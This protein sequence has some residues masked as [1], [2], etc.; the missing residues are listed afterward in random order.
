MNEDGL[1]MK[2]ETRNTTYF[3]FAWLLC[4]CCVLFLFGFTLQDDP[5]WAS[6]LDAIDA[7][8]D[9]IEKVERILDIAYYALDYHPDSTLKYADLAYETSRKAGHLK[10]MISV[11]VLKGI[12]ARS[13]KQFDQAIKHY[14][15]AISLNEPLENELR[16]AQIKDNLAN[17]FVMQGK[18]EKAINLKEEALNVFEEEQDTT[19]I[20][21]GLLGIGALLNDKGDYQNASKYF[22][23]SLIFAKTNRDKAYSYG[24]IGISHRH[25]NQPDSA[26][27]YYR[28]GIDIYPDEPIHL[29]RAYNNIAILQ[30]SENQFAEALASFE[31]AETAAKPLGN[32]SFIASIQ[33]NRAFLFTQMGEH[34]KAAELIKASG[35]VIDS[36]GSLKEKTDLMKV[37][38]QV[39]KSQGNDE[40]ALAHYQSFIYLRDSIDN[41]DLNTRIAD[42]EAK[43]ETAEKE[44]Q[45]AEQEAEIQ[46]RINQRNL[47]LGGLAGVIWFAT[48]AILFF[49]NRNR[50]NKVI[51]HQELEL[52]DQKI[53]QLEQEKRFL[54]I[55]SMLEGQENERMRIAQDLHDGI[56]GLLSSVKAH[57]SVIQK[58]IEK[59]E[60]YQ[61]SERVES[62]IDEASS[63]VR[64]ISHNMA[65][66]AIR[67]N[68]LKAAIQ[69]LAAQLQEA[70]QAKVDFE[71]NGSGNEIPETKEIM[72]YR[73][74]Q[75]LTNNIIKHAQ[76]S[77]VLI[78]VNMFDDDLNLIVEDDGV[79]FDL[80]TALA[81]K[82]LGLKSIRSRVDFL[83]G[84][85]DFDSRKGAGTTVSVQV[86]V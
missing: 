45:I 18:L 82:S 83:D 80:H 3:I 39:A 19:S 62:L 35:P 76:A 32:E 4:G 64:R 33:I 60:S 49:W 66:R 31:K 15:T 8:N 78:Q 52:Q 47:L 38:Y 51:T 74:I 42:F 34:Q 13:Q 10:G 57:F 17:V 81:Q 85:L 44:K 56:G 24:N 7:E 67:L 41:L 14:E 68:G 2:F 21:I 69:D 29:A 79:G 72:L 58:E 27:Y 61:L 20:Y 30:K 48:F 65:P 12:F 40:D 26:I 37:R 11:E 54:S 55:S 70:G 75:E 84:K 1:K 5:K 9:P 63:E 77:H 6:Y 73:I 50:M 16:A 36:T 25:Q 28:K 22:K 23:S 43:Y 86:P 71:W 53:S 59:I 46:Q